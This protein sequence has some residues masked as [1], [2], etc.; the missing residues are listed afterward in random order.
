[1]TTPKAGSVK[2][3]KPRNSFSG[4]T[5]RRLE[6]ARVIDL[7]KRRELKASDLRDLAVMQAAEL[8]E[9]DTKAS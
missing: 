9:C 4:N 6:L 1:M 8:M 2:S 7:S 3:Q 5:A